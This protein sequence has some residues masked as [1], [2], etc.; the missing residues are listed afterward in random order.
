MAGA[1]GAIQRAYAWFR[2]PIH[3]PS[4]ALAQAMVILA[5]MHENGIGGSTSLGKQQN[6][7]NVLHGPG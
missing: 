7:V 2:G 4:S 5:K 3:G 1:L 6:G